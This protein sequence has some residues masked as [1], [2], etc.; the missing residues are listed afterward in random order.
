MSLLATQ[1]TLQP[2]S[3]AAGIARRWVTNQLTELS[4][5]DLLESAILGV[6]EL[7]TNALLH[8]RGTIHVRIVEDD[9][10]LRIEVHDD[11]TRAPEGRST[12]VMSTSSNPST[13]GRG[14]QIVDSISLSWG[15]AYATAGKCVWFQPMPEGAESGPAAPEVAGSETAEQ[16]RRTTDETVA[17]ELIDVPVNLLVHYRIRFRDLRRELT[18]I[19]LDT[20][21]HSSVGGR[22]NDVARRLE[23]L[24][25]VG[26]DAQKAID[27]ALDAGL[28]R[29]SVTYKLPISAIDEI[30]ELR[31]LLLEAD[32]FCRARRLLTLAAGP[33]ES[34]M[35][36]WFLGELID[37]ARGAAPTPWRGDYV[38]T[39]PEPLQ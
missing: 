1:L 35:R 4:R 10:R 28:D 29:A 31:R 39:D 8:V 16:T 17:V 11:S 30:D 26:V 3:T 37:Q 32:E 14:L 34:A 27:E 19:A 9:S 36:A 7:V 22:L 33:Q 24:G 23:A 20:S 25:P 12:L 5:P 2:E 18:L 13:I 21:E 15:V 6:S 38:V